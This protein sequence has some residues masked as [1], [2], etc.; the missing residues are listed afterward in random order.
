MKI[1]VIV[2]DDHRIVREG[3][4]ALLE[5]EPDIDVIAQARDGL[6][7][8]R[9]ARQLNPDVVVTDM[10]MPGMNGIEVTRRIRSELPDCRVICLS[11]H[12]Q[13]RQ[14]LA[15]LDAGAS[16]YVLKDNS[17]DELARGIRCAMGNQLFLSVELI[18]TV[19]NARR[20]ADAAVQTEPA[21][22][23]TPREREIVQLFSEGYTTQAIAD[24]LSVSIKTVATH[25]ERVYQKL[26]IQGVAELTRYA[27]RE[28][29][30]SLDAKLRC[31]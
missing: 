31:A 3:L 8:A 11:V 25:R 17:F 26:H 12:D 9:L 6:E 4:V 27:L 24:S 28:G 29:L 18:G 15:A 30:T 10:T 7:L 20:T 5:R 16:G 22:G 2:C 14:V 23:L 1:R 13:T 19:L 21:A